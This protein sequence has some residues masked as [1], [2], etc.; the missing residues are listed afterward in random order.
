MISW[1]SRGIGE[2]PEVFS[3]E[4]NYSQKEKIREGFE[5]CGLCVRNSYGIYIKSPKEDVSTT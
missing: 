4:A 1:R 2:I 5:F 3:R